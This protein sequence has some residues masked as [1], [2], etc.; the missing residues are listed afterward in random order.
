[1]IIT[2]LQGYKVL[3]IVCIW[4]TEIFSV[5]VLLNKPP[6]QFQCGMVLSD[7]LLLFLLIVTTT[8]T[9]ITTSTSD[10][11]DF[12]QA[13]LDAATGLMCVYNQGNLQSNSHSAQ[14]IFHWRETFNLEIMG[15]SNLK[16]QVWHLRGERRDWGWLQWWCRCL[17]VRGCWPVLTAKWGA[18]TWP[19]P[20]STGLLSNTSVKAGH[21][22]RGRT[23]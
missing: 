8:T 2:F 15:N 12:S 4:P 3:Q 20:P 14:K 22:K 13:T 18:A 10:D 19:T 11:V 23:Q 1:M 7:P 5:R 16:W 17:V 21:I 9:T 6:S